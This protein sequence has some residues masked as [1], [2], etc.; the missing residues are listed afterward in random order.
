MYLGMKALPRRA[1]KPRREATQSMNSQD[2]KAPPGSQHLTGIQSLRGDNPSQQALSS[3]QQ[4]LAPHNPLHFD[5]RVPRYSQ[6]P[7]HSNLVQQ[8]Q[9][10]NERRASST[11]MRNEL[12]QQQPVQ[13][14]QQQ[15]VNDIS[16]STIFSPLLLQN[17]TG[18]LQQQPISNAQAAFLLQQQLLQQ[19]IQFQGQAGN[20]VLPPTAGHFNMVQP[21]SLQGYTIPPQLQ[22]AALHLLLQASVGAPQSTATTTPLLSGQD[23]TTT[24]DNNTSS[25]NDPTSTRASS[26]NE[27]EGISPSLDDRKRDRSPSPDS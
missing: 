2:K 13:Q 27:D 17:L 26:L 8:S 14:Q 11:F 7:P 1:K 16:S 22:Q 19:N 5:S 20:F 12:V 21:S 15:L 6:Q 25:S 4:V 3:Q 23:T 10:N 9:L 18:M 24:S